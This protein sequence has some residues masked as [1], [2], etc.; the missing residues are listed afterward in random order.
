[1]VWTLYC[2]STQWPSMDATSI[3]MFVPKTYPIPIDNLII[4]V[5]IIPPGIQ[6]IICVNVIKY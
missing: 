3:R 5:T 1:M 4:I 6:Y 2:K